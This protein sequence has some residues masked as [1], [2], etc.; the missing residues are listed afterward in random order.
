MIQVNTYIVIIFPHFKL[1]WLLFKTRNQNCPFLPS[2]LY[3]GYTATGKNPWLNSVGHKT[4]QTDENVGRG[5][6]ARDGF[7]EL[8]ER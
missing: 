5:D 1:F 6:E 2:G 8:R 7:M 4:K 3:S